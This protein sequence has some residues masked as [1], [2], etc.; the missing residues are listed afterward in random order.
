MD[1]IAFFWIGNK[2]NIPTLLVSSIRLTQGNKI[3]IIQLSDTKTKK[4]AGVDKIIRAELPQEIM[5]ARLKAYSLIDTKSSRTFFCDADT[6][7]LNKLNLN[8]FK[9]GIYLT[10]RPTNFI[11]NHNYPEYYPEFENKLISDV[12]PFLFGAIV[13]IEEENIFTNLFKICINLEK[14]FQRWYGDQVSLY[15]YYLKNKGKFLF[16]DQEKY[17]DIFTIDL[18]VSESYINNLIGQKKIFTTFKGPQDNERILNAFIYLKKIKR[19]YRFKITSLF[20]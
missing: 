3:K 2:I 14:R 10:K 7:M 16:L 8:I 20:K 6:L 9:K 19:S 12:M 1:Q 13:V 5:S 4:I 15:S 17:L 11:I 18:E